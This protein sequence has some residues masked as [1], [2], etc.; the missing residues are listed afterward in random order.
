MIII[1]AIIVIVSACFWGWA[2]NQIIA[3]KG[4][5]ENWFWIGFWLGIFAL[6]AACIRPQASRPW[7]SKPPWQAPKANSPQFTYEHRTPS[8][9]EWRCSCGRINKNYVSSCVCGF[10]KHAHLDKEIQSTVTLADKPKRPDSIQLDAEVTALEI[11]KSYKELLA[12]GAI[13][14]E[15]FNR[16]KQSI[17]DI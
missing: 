15:E 3:E 12:D 17:L 2:T 13:T 9:E 7:S 4:Y 8:V 16:K 14:E 1:S 6:I 11:I 5:D 10:S